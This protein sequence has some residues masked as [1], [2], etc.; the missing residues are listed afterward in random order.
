MH[1][2]A[3]VKVDTDPLAPFS[4]PLW[5]KSALLSTDN[6]TQGLQAALES[7]LKTLGS[8]L[9]DMAEDIISK[10]G[11]ISSKITPAELTKAFQDILDTIAGKTLSN[12]Q[13]LEALQEA[14]TNLEAGWLIR[15]DRD[16]GKIKIGID[17]TAFALALNGFFRNG[18]MQ[19]YA[20][21][22]TEVSFNP[23]SRF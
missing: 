8:E 14:V 23:P 1:S 5:R 9:S 17:Q 20:A 15:I 21:N 19:T 11:G 10:L 12:K 18:G 2:A 13:L 16:Q 22:C 6:A 3:H 7:S 4:N